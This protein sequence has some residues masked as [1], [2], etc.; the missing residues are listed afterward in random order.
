[1]MHA[2]AIGHDGPAARAA[3]KHLW[4]AGYHS[5][6]RLDEPDEV[7]PLLACV[8]PDVI[9]VLPDCAVGEPMK[10][11]RRISRAADAPVVVATHDVDH[12]LK[13]L[14]PVPS[15]E[16]AAASNPVELAQLPLAA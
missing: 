13:C 14:G 6:F 10:A 9:L 12:A 16:D 2:F 4:E 7:S 5:I 8:H 11:L 15:I 1:M 3:I